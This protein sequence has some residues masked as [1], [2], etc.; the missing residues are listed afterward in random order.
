VTEV[1]LDSNVLYSGF[2]RPESLPG[3][4]LVAVREGAHPALFSPELLREYRTVLLSPAAMRW[5]GQSQR[6]V[7]S[8]LEALKSVGHVVDPGIGP[9]CPDPRDQHLWD[10]LATRRDAVLV[11]GEHELLRSRLFPGRVL[12]PRDFAERYLGDA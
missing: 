11:T 9:D 7:F 2:G 6:R 8:F 12:S 1:V 3:L 5:H 4:V 10:L